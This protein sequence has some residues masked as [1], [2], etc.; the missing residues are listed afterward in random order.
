M[1]TTVFEKVPVC[2]LF[3]LFFFF[4]GVGK[5]YVARLPED[6]LTQKADELTQKA[7]ELTQKADE[8]TQKADELTQKLDCV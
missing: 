3:Y 7:D 8:L 5:P 4:R 1:K 2:F 6:E